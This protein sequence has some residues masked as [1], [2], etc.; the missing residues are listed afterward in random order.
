MVYGY[1]SFSKKLETGDLMLTLV[2]TPMGM[3]TEEG[4]VYTELLVRKEDSMNETIKAGE[5]F[6]LA[7]LV[8][9]AEGRIR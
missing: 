7:D 1:K 4:A 9:Y 8:P 3:R 6:K 2:G 5:V